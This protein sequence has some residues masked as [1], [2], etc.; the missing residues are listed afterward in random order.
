[1]ALIRLEDISK[2][3]GH[4]EGET[5]AVD[6][7]SLEIDKGEFVALMGPSGSGKSTLMNIMGLLDTP[8]NGYYEL[9]GKNVHQLREWQQAKIRLRHIGFVFQNFNL[10]ARHSAIE[11]VMLPMT[12]N[13]KDKMSRERRAEVLLKHVGLE[14]RMDHKPNELSGGEKQRVAIARALANQPDIILADEPTGNLDSKS[15]KNI[16]ELL[17]DLHK[18]GNTIILVTHDG[19]IAKAAKRTIRIKDGKVTSDRTKSKG[20]K[21]K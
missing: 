6:N 2:I 18:E 5:V 1:M 21:K 9:E 16:L 3:Y 12:Y 7:V 20:T 13:K 8:T 19:N 11:N 14:E 10:L 15:G 4:G 17:K